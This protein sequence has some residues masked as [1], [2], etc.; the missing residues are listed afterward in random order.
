ML[1]LVRVWLIYITL[2]LDGEP[3]II[4]VVDFYFWFIF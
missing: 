2:H 4:F 3:T 1:Q